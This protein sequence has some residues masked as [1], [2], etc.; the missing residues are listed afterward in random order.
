[1]WDVDS[2]K[3]AYKPFAVHDSNVTAVSIGAL[4]GR[5]IAVS[6]SEDE[7]LWVW[8]LDAGA[9]LGRLEGHRD[10]VTAVA[11]GHLGGR[12]I[13]VSGSHDKTVRVRDLDNGAPLGMN[14]SRRYMFWPKT[15]T[16][17]FRLCGQGRRER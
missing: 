10:F 14:C 13:A 1:M 4:H 11:L 12:P 9:P 6:A 17:D 8:D 15:S 3:L 2:G 16:R 5:P 7:T